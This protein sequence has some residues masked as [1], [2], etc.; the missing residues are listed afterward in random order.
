[1][2]HPGLPAGSDN[3]TIVGTN[4]WAADGGAPLTFA[5]KLS[6]LLG[7]NLAYLEE[8]PGELRWVFASRGFAA[9]KHVPALGIE[10]LPQAAAVELAATELERYAEGETEILNHS[11]RTFHF[12]ELLHKQSS[13]RLPLD[14]E[15]LAVAALLHDVGLYPKA[16]AEIDGMDFTVRGA[17]I[18]RR[19]TQAAG[20]PQ[21]RIDLAAQAITINANGRVPIHW[22]AEAYFGRLAPLVD[23]VGQ[24]WKVHPD[25]ARSIFSAWPAADLDRAILRA[26]TEEA[27]RHP[28]SR[29][30]LFKPLFPFLVM[31]CKR[32]WQ[33]RLAS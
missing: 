18:G 1:M 12:A 19:V 20:W 14:R 26:V 9:H 33:R 28:G 24:C 27:A 30:A 25:D 15:V 6:Q 5:Q 16:V 8:L 10:D 29:F 21:H 23:A 22:G 11:Y 31:N 13:A 4:A 17:R 32:R 3:A 7:A 2:S